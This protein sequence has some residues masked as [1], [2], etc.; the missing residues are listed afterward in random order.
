MT[1]LNRRVKG[2]E[3]IWRGL[4]WDGPIIAESEEATPGFSILE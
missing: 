2:K 3:K 1:G 4:R